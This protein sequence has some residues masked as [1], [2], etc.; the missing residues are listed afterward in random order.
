MGGSKPKEEK[1]TLRGVE[2]GLK[3]KGALGA[4]DNTST[5]HID[6][7]GHVIVTHQSAAPRG[8]RHVYTRE[9]E[10]IIRQ[11][12][13]RIEELTKTNKENKRLGAELEELLK[14]YQQL[15]GTLTS[16]REAHKHEVEELRKKIEELGEAQGTDTAE[17]NNMRHLLSLLEALL[18]DS[19]TIFELQYDPQASLFK[20]SLN[21]IDLIY[22]PQRPAL[23]AHSRPGVD[24]PTKS[25]SIELDGTQPTEAGLAF[26]STLNSIVFDP[27]HTEMTEKWSKERL[28]R[29]FVSK[30]VALSHLELDR[31]SD[32]YYGPHFH[33]VIGKALEKAIGNV[34]MLAVGTVA[35]IAANQP[36]DAPHRTDPVTPDPT[37]SWTS[38]AP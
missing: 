24:H 35:E 38:S 7:S 21:G 13:R 36:E 33:G 3:V 30:D 9:L 1:R 34:S 20:I 18:A 4:S 27:A 37:A 14:S 11:L 6:D 29:L 26:V 8:P 12:A 5:F 31:D 17:L 15:D 22:E 10:F 19:H 16:V 23:T 32:M 2:L 25:Q 28:G